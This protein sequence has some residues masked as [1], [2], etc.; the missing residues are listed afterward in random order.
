VTCAGSNIS[1]KTCQ[2]SWSYATDA[3]NSAIGCIGLYGTAT[4]SN[5]I[6]GATVT[7]MTK[8]T[9][10]TLSITYQLRFT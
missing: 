9:S 3:G 1:S 10:Q 6:A 7:P 4:G 8:T 5:L 2:S